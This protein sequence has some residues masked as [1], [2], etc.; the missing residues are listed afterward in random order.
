MARPHIDF[1]HVDDIA[2]VELD[3]PGGNKP[4]R[5]KPLSRDADTG[6]VT[7]IV[8]FPPGFERRETGY[9][10]SDEDL[11]YL[12]GEMTWGDR[13]LHP[14]CYA[15]HPAGKL[16]EPIRTAA[17]TVVFASFTETPHWHPS[18]RPGPMFQPERDVS[19]VDIRKV[20]WESPRFDDFPAGASRKALRNDPGAQQGASI[21]GLLPQW[22]SPYTEW[23]TFSEEVYIL[24]GTIDT[25]FGK[26]TEGAYLAHPPEDVHGPMHSVD[27]CMFFVIVRGPIGNTYEPVD[28]YELP[29][30]Q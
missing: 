9:N 18:D 23:H 27:G 1:I 16:R 30:P 28:G 6:G 26:M 4:V 3:L 2:W 19:Y 13:T 22:I 20:P 7:A 15:F 29:P 5:M 8:E 10:S 14:H 12:E 17:G 24:E 21:N 25:T 11:F